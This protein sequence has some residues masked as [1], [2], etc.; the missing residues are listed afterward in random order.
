VTG[1][2]EWDIPRRVW[3]I[4]LSWGLAVLMIAGLLSLWIWTNQE[5]A[6]TERDRAQAQQDQAMCVMLD[7]FTSGPEPVP[8]PAGERGRAVVT[9]MRAY[10]STLEC[11]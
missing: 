7:L 1:Q 11:S 4:L 5:R 6:A 8:G 2:N 10:R 9:A 3:F